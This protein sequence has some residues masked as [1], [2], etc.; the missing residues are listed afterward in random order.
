MQDKMK[1]ELELAVAY[2]A[3]FFTLNKPLVSPVQVIT[4]RMHCKVFQLHFLS[5]YL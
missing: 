5:A 1:Q 3:C 4:L 2:C